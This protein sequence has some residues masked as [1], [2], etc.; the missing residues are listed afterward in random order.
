MTELCDTCGTAAHAAAAPGCS[1]A[2][3]S[4]GTGLSAVRTGIGRARSAV[5]QATAAEV[6]CLMPWP[7]IAIAGAS[8][9]HRLW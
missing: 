9:R 7:A 8:R 3:S 2:C 5:E 1:C 4:H 6:R